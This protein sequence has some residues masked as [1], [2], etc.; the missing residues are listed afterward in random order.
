[1]ANTPQSTTVEEY[2]A[3]LTDA[4]TV[5]DS[6]ELI[7]MMKKISGH[8]PVIW[9]VGTIGFDTYHYKYESGREGDCH[10]LGFYPRDGKI[11]FYLMDGTN[12]HSDLLK[13]LGK[14][15]TSK[16][17]VYIKRLSDVDLHILEKLLRDSYTYI[18]ALDGK[19][20]RM[21]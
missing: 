11:T 14:H 8:D 1:M 9:N 10:V 21:E 7:S 15:T 16:A 20:H 13:Q 12:Q 19:M 2:L 4:Q 18:K 6:R 5:Q 3:T 17:C